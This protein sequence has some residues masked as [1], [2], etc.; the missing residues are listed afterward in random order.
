MCTLSRPHILRDNPGNNIA[1]GG[2]LRI[3]PSQEHQ[4][5]YGKFLVCL[6][7]AYPRG[8]YL[9]ISQHIR[10]KESYGRCMSLSIYINVLSGKIPYIFTKCFNVFF[11]GN[12]LIANLHKH[13]FSI[14]PDLPML[15]R[16]LTV[17]SMHGLMWYDH[18]KCLLH[19]SQCNTVHLHHWSKHMLDW[20]GNMLFKVPRIHTDSGVAGYAGS[21]M[22]T[23][24]TCTEC[25]T[26]CRHFNSYPKEDILFLISLKFISDGPINNNSASVQVLVCLWGG[27]RMWTEK[28]MA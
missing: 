14:K 17:I 5:Y 8:L 21:E 24:E 16:L 2:I 19:L 25:P 7:L 23:F 12:R 22:N 27:N 20:L 28:L 11:Y 13:I 1:L 3:L 10:V 6:D 18:P 26:F 15:D 9:D 4:S